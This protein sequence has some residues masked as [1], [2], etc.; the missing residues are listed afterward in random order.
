MRHHRLIGLVVLGATPLLIPAMA[1]G[2]PEKP[3]PFDD[4]RLEI[5]FNATDGDAGFQIFADAEEWKQ[6]EIFRPDGGRIVNFQTDGN[7]DDFGLTELFSESSEPPFERFPLG[8]FKRLFPAG[9]YRFAGRTI[10][11]RELVGRARLSHDIPDGPE[12]TSPVAGAAVPRAAVV[13]S[14]NPVP[15]RGGVEI[16]GYRAI[17]EREHPLRVF[18]ADLPAS[19][20]SIT[21]PAQFLEA[22]TDYKLEVQAIEA[23][24][25]QTLTEITFRVG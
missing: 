20:H 22:G 5:E 3:T 13:A 15:E 9:T 16:A 19:A 12:I 4:A 21:I 8:R 2:A 17:V 18:S 1:Q 10:D 6:F 7:L 14:W 23:S 24:G 25:N 11:G